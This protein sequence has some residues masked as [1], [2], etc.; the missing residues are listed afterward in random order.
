MHVA[1]HDLVRLLDEGAGEGDAPLVAHLDGCVEC[2]ARRATLER[3][4]ERLREWLVGSDLPPRVLTLR[5]RA[6][7]AAS[8]PA[9]PAR[10]WRL[11][12]AFA[13][14][15]MGSMAVPP[16]RAWIESSARS[17]LG[18]LTGE[19]SEPSREQ[20]RI[21]PAP[22]DTAGL[23][24]FSPVSR[25]LTLEVATRQAAGAV[26]LEAVDDY[27]VAAL[28]IGE[29]DAADLVVLPGRLRILNRANSSASYWVRVPTSLASVAIHIGDE[30]EITW[31]P[32][33][34]GERLSIPLRVGQAQ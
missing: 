8:P 14:L 20:D 9:Q 12:A 29:R 24:R 13:A 1:E 11:A 30:P 33:A 2:A 34:V 22:I 17:W 21:G 27:E 25:Q 26:V 6:V 32:G 23:V 10:G 28:A 19:S 15:F 4:S 7:K 5:P 3:R 18:F 31:R 16:V